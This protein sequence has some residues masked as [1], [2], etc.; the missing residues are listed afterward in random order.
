[1][2]RALRVDKLTIAALEYTLVAYL[3]GSGAEGHTAVPALRMIQMTAEEIAHR[4]EKFLS[5]LKGLLPA[6]SAQIELRDSESVVGGGSTPGQP[7]ATRVITIQSS[8]HS[9]AE[10]ESRLRQPARGLPVIA[11][12]E[13][14][15]LLL[16]LRTV[17]PEQESALAECLVAALKN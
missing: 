13:D 15:R 5:K 10:L 12:V 7:L 8:S 1:M 6:G 3:R 17:Y 11:R 16:D 14:D 4:S 9:P 2:F